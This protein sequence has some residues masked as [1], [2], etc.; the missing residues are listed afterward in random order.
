MLLDHHSRGAAGRNRPLNIGKLLK[1]RV[2]VPLYKVQLALNDL[3]ESIA[4]VRSRIATDISLL[5]EYRTR[6]VADVVTGKLDVRGAAAT[7][8]EVA[9]PPETLDEVEEMQQD[10]ESA[11]TEFEAEEAA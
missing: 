3:I 4:P 11:E 6:L 2:P 7:L 10:E 9:L 5:G 8:Q 1:E